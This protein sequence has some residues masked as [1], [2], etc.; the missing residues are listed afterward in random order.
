LHAAGVQVEAVGEVLRAEH[1]EVRPGEYLA[2]ADGRA[3]RLSRRELGLLTALL[4]EQKRVISREDLYRMVWGG[5]LRPDDR[6]IDVY[7]HKLRVKLADALPEWTYIHTHFGFGYRFEAER[8]P[9]G[10]TAAT[11]R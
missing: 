1:L 11:N 5:R 10:N 4:R 3:L 2:L 8:S 9:A 7:I 6:S